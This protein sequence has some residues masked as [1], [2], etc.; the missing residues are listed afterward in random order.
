MIHFFV[1]YNE[2]IMSLSV[3]ADCYTRILS[4]MTVYILK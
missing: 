2:T 3:V 4:I 1:N